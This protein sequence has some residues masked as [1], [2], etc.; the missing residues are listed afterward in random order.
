MGLDLGIIKEDNFQISKHYED[1]LDILTKQKSGV[2]Y[3]PKIIIR[4]M[5]FI[6]LPI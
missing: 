1:S 3:T 6:H 4:C 2:F 5:P